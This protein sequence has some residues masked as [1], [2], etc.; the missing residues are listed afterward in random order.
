MEA[1]E[2]FHKSGYIS[3]GLVIL[4]LNNSY[5]KNLL[6]QPGLTFSQV[7]VVTCFAHRRC[8]DLCTGPLLSKTDQ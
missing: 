8:A 7:V 4:V 5:L 1:L 2:Y 6:V 3:S